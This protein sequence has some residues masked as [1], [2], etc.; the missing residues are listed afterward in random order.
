MGPGRV[1]LRRPVIDCCEFL[2]IINEWSSEVTVSG[3]KRA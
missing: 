3:T 2:C 1:R